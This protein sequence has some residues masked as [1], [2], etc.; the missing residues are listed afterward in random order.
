M[1][2]QT[3][4][5]VQRD[6]QLKRYQLFMDSSLKRAIK[7]SSSFIYLFFI[8]S[9]KSRHEAQFSDKKQTSVCCRLYMQALIV[10]C[11]GWQRKFLH[12]SYFNWQLVFS[13]LDYDLYAAIYSRVYASPLV[14]KYLYISIKIIRIDFK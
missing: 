2:L 9:P 3:A 14:N 1:S 4:L 5:C 12:L 8:F 6:V 13:D 10:K 7:T 11:Y